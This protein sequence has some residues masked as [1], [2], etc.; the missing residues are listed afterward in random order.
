MGEEWRSVTGYEGVYDVSNLGRVRRLLRSTG[1]RPGKILRPGLATGGYLTVSFCVNCK[2]KTRAVHTL[3]A[4]AFIGSSPPKH[5]VDY[6]D[7]DKQ[8][9]RLTNLR[10]ATKSSQQF[11]TNK[12]TLNGRACSSRYTGVTYRWDIEKWQAQMRLDGRHVSLGVYETEGHAAAS[13]KGAERM[14]EWVKR[15][16]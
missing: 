15:N 8:N 10:Y 3:V 14:L 16:W 9:N 13:R 2:P 4:E 11:N 7:R 6:I 5:E 1:T 12:R